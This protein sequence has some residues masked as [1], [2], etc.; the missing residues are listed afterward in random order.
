MFALFLHLLYSSASVC[1]AS[2]SFSAA[3]ASTALTAGALGASTRPPSSSTA[4]SGSHLSTGAI[5]IGIMVA[6]VVGISVC[7][8]LQR[9]LTLYFYY[10]SDDENTRP[11]NIMSA[12][13]NGCCDM[14]CVSLNM[15]VISACCPAVYAKG[16]NKSLWLRG[17]QVVTAVTDA[18]LYP[19]PVVDR[20]HHPRIVMMARGASL[21]PVP[22]EELEVCERDAL[23]SPCS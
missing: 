2:S 23:L 22:E 13:D 9:L 21:Y 12:E 14:C 3:L 6:I 11:N 1:L 10:N 8:W 17:T 5:I 7:V 19:A 16:K 4:S 15:A 18:P 20:G